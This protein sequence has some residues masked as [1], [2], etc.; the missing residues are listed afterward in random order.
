ME[1]TM[2]KIIVDGGY[3]L[4]GKVDISGMKNA[5]VAVIFASVVVSGV[6]IIDNLPCISDVSDSLEILK[7]IG[8]RVRAISGTAVEI[9]TT[10]IADMEAPLD[11]V[12][13]LRA[14]YYLA[15]AMLGRFGHAKVGLPGGCDFGVRPI[16]LHVKA[17]EKLGAEVSVGGG[18]YRGRLDGR[19]AWQQHLFR[20]F[21]RRGNHQHHHRRRFGGRLHGY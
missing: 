1:F 17:F 15:G 16:D 7:S 12:R 3:P 10:Q 6:C 5:A 4:S 13:R 20:L 21:V 11:L 2:E 19:R 18:L 8:A 9:D 14:S